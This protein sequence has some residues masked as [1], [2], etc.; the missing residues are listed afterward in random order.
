MP[1]HRMGIFSRT[2]RHMN[3]YRQ[4]LSILFKY[5]FS[6][7]V[8]RIN[9]GRY[10]K[11]GLRMI[12]R[13][14]W[15]RMEKL[16]QSERIRMAIEELGPTFVKLAQILSTRPDLIPLQYLQELEKL[17]DQVPPFPFLQVKEIVED[18]LKAPLDRKFEQFEKTPLAAASI[19]QVHRARLPGGEEVVVKV[20]R[21]R[22]RK[23]IGVDLEILYHLA[24]LIERYIEE[25]EIQKPTRIVEEFARTLEKELDYTIEASHAERFARLFHG[26]PLIYI[27]RVH[28]EISTSR[29]LT[30]EYIQ[31]IKASELALLD[32]MGFDRKVIA[33]RGADLILQQVFKYGFFHAD[34]HPGNI[35]L[36]PGNVICYLDFGMMGSVDR[37]ARE[38]FAD[39]VFGY[40]QQ[41]PSQIVQ[42]LL[43]IVEWD[44]EPNRRTLE[45]DIIEFIELHGGKPLKELRIGSL[46]KKLQELITRHRLRLPPDIFLMIKAMSTIEGIGSVLDPD[47]DLIEKAAPF[48]RK[49]RLERF[50]PK[51]VMN[52]LFDLGGDLFHLFKE[53]PEKTGDILKQIKEGK[54]KIRFEHRGLENFILQIDRASNRIAFSLIISSLI[55]GSSLIIRTNMG[56]FLL[57]FPLFGLLGFSIAGILGLGLIISILRSGKF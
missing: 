40:V 53:I 55:V 31:G 57:G 17:Q 12:S 22:I 9:A 15:E 36:L 19:G 52:E 11:L 14:H 32:K 3:R 23:I 27:P 37:Q 20:Q 2:Y 51:R 1:L 35:F 13:K 24:T 44:S 7:L 46:L 25:W 29:I 16:T 50:H 10:L 30:M 38:D 45:R 47:F 5:G 6:D 21:P 42:T 4:I 48:I 49:I 56:P 43:K 34:P 54:V 28:R 8:D 18:E 41:D 26:N 39:I 33:S